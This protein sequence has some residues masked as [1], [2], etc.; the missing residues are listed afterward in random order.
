MGHGIS[1][2]LIT[3]LIRG[4]VEELRPLA[5]DPGKF[6][7]TLN[8]GMCTVLREAGTTTFASAIYAVI[9]ART[10]LMRYSIAGHPHPFHLR[11]KSK[12]VEAISFAKKEIGPVL[13]LIEET[14]YPT[15]ERKL[16][17]GDVLIIYTDGI[18]E[19]PGKDNEEYGEDRL[20]G[21]FAKRASLD[22]DTLFKEVVGEV[23]A[24][25]ANSHFLD[26]VCLLG[27]QLDADCVVAAS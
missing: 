18:F 27:V 19:V 20:L 21:S 4:L 11:Q 26:D 13:G 3:A 14:T 15:L 25:S 10:Q 8:R 5:A 22:V 7:T 24:W 9:D 17:T 1:P 16:D 12:T 6:L 23:R 2:A